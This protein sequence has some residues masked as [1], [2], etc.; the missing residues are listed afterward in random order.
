MTTFCW[1]PPDRLVIAFSEL[2]ERICSSSAQ[3]CTSARSRRRLSRPATQNGRNFGS[4][5]FSRTVPVGSSA[6][7]AR[8]AG[9]WQIPS[10]TAAF[11]SAGCSTLPATRTVPV[12]G[13]SPAINWAISS[14][15]EPVSPANPIT[16]PRDTEK[17]RSRTVVPPSPV[18]VSMASAAG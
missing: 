11:G 14:R 2:P 18:T 6:L 5:R 9:T 15:P 1:F 4:V 10:A 7:R 13:W 3:R 17:S 12:R 8:S 16:S